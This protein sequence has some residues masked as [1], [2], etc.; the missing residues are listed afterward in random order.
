MFEVKDG[1]YAWN[2]KYYEKFR[3]VMHA[4][5]DD[6]SEGN[7]TLEFGDLTGLQLQGKA[8]SQFLLFYAVVKLDVPALIQSVNADQYRKWTRMQGPAW[9]RRNNP[10]FA[11][12]FIIPMGYESNR[13]M[14]C[15]IWP[16]LDSVYNRDTGFVLTKKGKYRYETV[17][18]FICDVTLFSGND[19]PFKTA[20]DVFVT[21]G[22]DKRTFD[23][24]KHALHEDLL[25]L[26][27]LAAQLEA[28]DITVAGDAFIS[29]GDV[30]ASR[31]A[32]KA[33]DEIYGDSSYVNDMLSLP[34][35]LRGGDFYTWLSYA[36]EAKG[37][38]VL[39]D[40][41]PKTAAEVDESA[42]FSES[43]PNFV[44]EDEEEG[45]SL[46]PERTETER[47]VSDDFLHGPDNSKPVYV[48]GKTQYDKFAGVLE[49]IHKE[50]VFH[51][52][53]VEYCIKSGTTFDV[54][55]SA[56]SSMGLSLDEDIY[57]AVPV[58]LRKQGVPV[59]VKMLC[60]YCKEL[61]VCYG[62]CTLRLD[63]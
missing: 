19:S 17:L 53:C 49:Q 27:I 44:A 4:I 5:G 9:I 31:Y 45:V 16:A 48:P 29:I 36:A 7:A 57:R 54:V 25:K 6:I 18:S 1:R 60:E 35:A 28:G 61:N 59:D 11:R 10:L 47:P 58:Y 42:T 13:T 63:A 3:D 52:T 21:L 39:I 26:K 32:C 8:L 24:D 51:K 38:H 15:A 2:G 23:L 34:P 55:K 43:T 14:H 22:N 41:S 20:L 12:N 37:K 30:R 33:K 46:K 40:A 56:L 62:D 50:Q